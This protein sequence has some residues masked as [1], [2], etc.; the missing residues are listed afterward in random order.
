MRRSGK[1][2]DFDRINRI[3]RIDRIDSGEQ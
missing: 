3:C 2:K 1:Q